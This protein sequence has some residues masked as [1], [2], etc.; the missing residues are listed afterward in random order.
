MSVEEV[1][2]VDAIGVEQ[3]TGVVVLTISDH[4]SWQS[5]SGHLAS[6]QAKIN[7][8]LSFLESGEVYRKYEASRG[9]TFR[10]EVVFS[11]S[12]PPGAERFLSNARN[13]VEHAG[14]TLSWRTFSTDLGMVTSGE[15]LK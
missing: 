14:F 1:A 9:R 6:L 8:Y 13:A 7:R 10:I 11:V 15:T 3:G 12:P 4:L 5:E 2:V